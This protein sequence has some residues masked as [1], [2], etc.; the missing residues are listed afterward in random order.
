M[1][2]NY[3][4]RVNRSNN[5]KIKTNSHI[6]NDQLI[7]NIL[8]Q[9]PEAYY[10]ILG[11]TISVSNK[12]LKQIY[13]RLALRLHPDKSPSP[14]AQ[15]AFTLVQK[16][17]QILNNSTYKSFYDKYGKDPLILL[18]KIKNQR[19]KDGCFHQRD[20]N[21]EILNMFLDHAE[22]DGKFVVYQN[23]PKK[24][25]PKQNILNVLTLLFPLIVIC[26]LP[27]VESLLLD[28]QLD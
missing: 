20:P 23:T 8:S 15:E 19:V 26:L 7:S 22:T 12:D 13:K 9:D 28:Q 24:K 27:L 1:I 14:N 5:M 21:G 6:S 11:T 3:K 17:Y 16:A 18:E 4:T 25:E 2:L 10:D